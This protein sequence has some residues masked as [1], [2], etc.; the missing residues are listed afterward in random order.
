MQEN[1]NFETRRN[2]IIG[3]FGVAKEMVLSTCSNNRVTSRVVSTAC[4]GDK[5]CFLSW[6]HHTKCLQ[7]QE[8]SSVALCYNNIQI[9]G[10]ASIKGDPFEKKNIVYSEK[11]KEKQVDL[12][13]V[14]SKFKGMVII[15]VSITSIRSYVK[16]SGRYYL[17]CLNFEE[18][19]A[20]RENME[21]D[22]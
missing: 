9:E 16:D 8:N 2:E 5:I 15:E 22:A 14:F 20:Y 3:S 19:T 11:Y 4:H 13:E 12:F 7:I 21:V 6:S 17:D 18:K 10:T 1:L